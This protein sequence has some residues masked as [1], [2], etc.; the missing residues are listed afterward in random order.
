[1]VWGDTLHL[2]VHSDVASQ[3]EDVDGVILGDGGGVDD[4]GGND[5]AMHG[6]T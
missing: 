3:A 2:E 5:V 4:G 6:S 1:M